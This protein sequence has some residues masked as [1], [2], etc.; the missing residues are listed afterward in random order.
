MFRPDCD[1]LDECIKRN[2][3][4]LGQG[5]YKQSFELIS[6]VERSYQADR[7]VML[8]KSMAEM[9]MG[10]YETAKMILVELYESN[11]FP[12]LDLFIGS[13]I[14][15]LA[16]SHS[17]KADIE[18]YINGFLDILIKSKNEP[19]TLLQYDDGS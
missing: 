6:Y 16:D 8:Y 19:C 4:L 1:S 10:N 14:G 11:A 9:G 17:S 2:Q 15:T 5:D 12:C 18:N 13:A 3:I 7:T